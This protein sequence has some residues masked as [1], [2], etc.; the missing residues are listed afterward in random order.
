M[1]TPCKTFPAIL[2]A[3]PACGII[4]PNKRWIY[5]PRCCRAKLLQVLP[6]TVCKD[7]ILYC[8]VCKAEIVV[9]IDQVPVP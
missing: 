3:S 4:K 1:D 5:C 9:N 2:T 8:K 7:L 6:T